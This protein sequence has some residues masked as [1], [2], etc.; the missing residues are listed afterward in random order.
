[1]IIETIKSKLEEKLK[2]K[3]TKPSPKNDR[4]PMIQKMNKNG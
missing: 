2:S 3:N 1:M 4:Q